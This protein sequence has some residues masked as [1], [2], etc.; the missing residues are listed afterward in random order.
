VKI[1]N[2]NFTT[3]YSADAIQQKIAKYGGT[4]MKLSWREAS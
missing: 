3:L 2:G 4:M 1:A